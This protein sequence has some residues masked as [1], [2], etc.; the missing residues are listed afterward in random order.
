MAGKQGG[1]WR[2][3]VD[4][5]PCCNQAGSRAVPIQSTTRTVPVRQ[6]QVGQRGVWGGCL[7]VNGASE[8]YG[9][10]PT[11]LQVSACVS[12]SACATRR[13]GLLGVV[14]RQTGGC[15]RRMVA[16]RRGGSPVGNGEHMVLPPRERA[17]LPSMGRPRPGAKRALY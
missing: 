10:R 3:W 16:S 5:R 12:C 11:Q 2:P 6:E 13:G 15:T 8:A 9:I 1:E 14:L 17:R 4:V 7:V